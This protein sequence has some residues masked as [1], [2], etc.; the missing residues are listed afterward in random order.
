MPIFQK[1]RQAFSRKE[2][3]V[4]LFSRSYFAIQNAFSNA[5]GTSNAELY[6]GWI[7]ACIRAIAERVGSIEL[8]LV[9]SDRGGN[10]EIIYNHPAI[11]ALEYV[12]EYFTRF[13]LFERLQSNLELEGKEYWILY[14]DGLGS[15][16]EIYPVKPSLIQPVRSQRDFISGY[17]YT[18]DGESFLLKPEDVIPF[19]NFNPASDIEGLSTLDAVRTVAQTDEYA[20]L[21]NK[22]FFENAARPDMVLKFKQELTKEQK[23][24][25]RQKLLQE[26]AGVKKHGKAMILDNNVDVDVLGTTQ[27]DMQFIEGRRFTRDE[28]LAIFRVPKIAA[29]I[30]EDINRA[31]AESALYAF[32]TYTII[33]KMERIADTLN[34]FYLPLFKDSDGL[35][36]EVATKA[37][38]DRA[39][40][41][42]SLAD[43][44]NSGIFSINDARRELGLPEIE[45]GEAVFLPFGAI[46]YA[47]PV[48]RI[49]P[50]STETKQNSFAVKVAGNI[51]DTL[52]DG[53][54]FGE[55]APIADEASEMSELDKKGEARVKRVDDRLKPFDKKFKEIAI[56]IF[57][58]QKMRAIKNL[59]KLADDLKAIVNTPYH[60]KAVRSLLD[61]K[62]EIKLTA[63]LFEPEFFKLMSEQGD[64]ALAYIGVASRFDVDAASQF[65]KENVKLLAAGMTETTLQGLA[66]TLEVGV[67]QG[68]SIPKLRKRIEKY[69]GFTPQRAERI[70]QTETVRANGM[71]DIY[72]WTQSEVVESK[73]WYAAMD[74]RTCDFCSYMHGRTVEL[75]KVFLST[76]QI[77]GIG[78]NPYEPLQ[79]PP[80]HVNCRCVLLPNVKV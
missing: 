23:D 25:I 4:P 22:A 42:M 24:S 71:A 32:M 46:P 65:I 13:T 68:E 16:R 49:S 54:L 15:P 37:P 59:D 3:P 48:K 56:G 62:N 9:K 52:Q 47:E 50:V 27:T 51:I 29:G 70:A 5:I 63:E 43:G 74:E 64:D 76:S 21:Y 38:E 35:K 61:K 79:S 31:S 60:I 73:T 55:V 19:R 18:I 69:A 53:G 33:P 45:N 36:F 7:Y 72:A 78:L 28:I 80:L 10:K 39:A 57:D 14:R 58:G 1:L 11:D 2:S 12:N 34:E 8:N 20:K 67:A 77:V 30:M 44:I 17:K 26:Y 41:I 66:R 6:R 75:D 40:T